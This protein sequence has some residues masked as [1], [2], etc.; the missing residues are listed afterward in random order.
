MLL[1]GKIISTTGIETILDSAF[2]ILCST[3]VLVEN[4]EM[5]ERLAEFGAAIDKKKSIAVF[6]HAFLDAFISNSQRVDWS[7]KTMSFHASAEIYQGWYLDPEDGE[8]KAWTQERLLKYIKV[9][10]NLPNIE[11]VTMLGYPALRGEAARL[12]PLYEKIF[13]WKYGIA[14]GSAIWETALCPQIFHLVNLY[15]QETGQDIATVY[16]GG[17]FLIS[18]LKF[19]SV[20]AE[21]FMYFY[22]RG[23]RTSVGALGALGMSMP[24]TLA[25]ALALHIAEHLF[26]NILDRAFFGSRTISMMN[27]VSAVDMSSGALQYGRPEQVILNLAGAQIAEYL[28]AEYMGHGGLSDAKTPGNESGA[29]KVISAIFNAAAGGYGHIAAGLLGIDEIFSPVQMI[30]D[31]EIVG[32]LNRICKGFEINDETLALEL[33]REVGQGGI[34]IDKEHTAQNFRD[35]LWNP[36]VWSKVMYNAWEAQ[37]AKSEMDYAKEK[38]RDILRTGR[39]VQPEISEALEAKLMKSIGC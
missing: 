30:L 17:V 6:S 16:K 36:S 21:Q 12:Q 31:N 3:G 27:S 4:D 25:G 13:C 39:D 20:E 23:L 19:G 29:Q 9:A 18:P 24:V 34:F 15:A 10:R 14:G 8:K 37:G 2:D 7:N 22:K 33:I 38:Y 11:R 26:I 32:A 28:G 5:L 1:G 35:S